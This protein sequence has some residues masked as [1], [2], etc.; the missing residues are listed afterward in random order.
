MRARPIVFAN[1]PLIGR[2]SLIAMSPLKGSDLDNEPRT[3]S[4]KALTKEIQARVHALPE[5]RARQLR[6]IRRDLSK[7]LI[8][9]DSH[10]VLRLALNLL[11]L[12]AFEFRFIAYELVQHHRMAASSLDAATLEKLGNGIDSWAAV[13]CF[14]CYLAGPAWREGH[15]GDSVVRRW[16]RSGDRWWRRAALVA[17]VPLNNKARGGTGDSPRTLKICRLMV[18]DRDPMVTKALSWTLRELTKRDSQAVREF[19]EKER[20]RLA[21]LVRREVEHKLATGLKNPRKTQKR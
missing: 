5:L 9:S 6:A 17:T 20:D 4:V 12:S 14:A 21:P 13:D 16:S 2:P 18:D 1:N 15:I 19:L 7:R 10:F 3:I 11:E 8:N